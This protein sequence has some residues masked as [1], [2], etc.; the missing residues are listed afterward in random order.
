MFVEKYRMSAGKNR[1][2]LRAAK[3][4][5]KVYACTA[6]RKALL[7]TH[8]KTTDPH[9][10]D[11]RLKNSTKHNKRCVRRFHVGEGTYTV[12]KGDESV[13]ADGFPCW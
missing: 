4:E 1:K 8:V 9:D 7:F 5:N 2:C 13:V 11:Q 3:V 12:L 10:R 6:K